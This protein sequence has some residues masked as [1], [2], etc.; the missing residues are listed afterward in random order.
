[1][2]A[3]DHAIFVAID[4]KHRVWYEMLIPFILSLRETD[5]DGHIVV[6]DYGLA[7][8][9][10]DLLLRDGV[11]IAPSTPGHDLSY[12]RYCEV[13]RICAGNPSLRKVALYDADIWFCAERFDL[14]DHVTDDK[15]Y[16]CRDPMF[17]TFIQ[18]PLIGPRADENWR[19]VFD[20]IIAR[21]GGALQAGVVAGSASAWTAFAAHIEDCASRIGTDFRRIFGIDTTFL[22]LWAVD[23]ELGILPETQNF[24]TKQG[25]IET[26]R[27]DRAQPIWAAP[28]GPITALHMCG[29]VR[30]FD[31]WRYYANFPDHGLRVGAR[32]A[33][34]AGEMVPLPGTHPIYGEA[35]ADVLATVNLATVSVESEVP[36]A[37]AIAVFRAAAGV[38]LHASG[39]H[40]ILL[41]ATRDIPAMELYLDSPAGFPSP[42][43]RMFKVGGTDTITPNHVTTKFS[44]T[45]PRGEALEL[46]AESLGGQLCEM[47]WI[48]NHDRHLNL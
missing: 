23:H 26:F 14:F 10:K 28:D 8:W 20:D 22:H 36:D 9:K 7:E 46:R 47:T 5:F 30:Y 15:L 29:D 37:R 32:F 24:I 6:I 19:R 43:R 21:Y 4:D 12:G 34:T 18:A 35:A 42:L 40:R 38:F 39:N 41:T 13:A 2:A 45:L 3:T 31:R 33:P 25:V 16:A 11:H 1:M 17:S 44:A 27:R 48:I